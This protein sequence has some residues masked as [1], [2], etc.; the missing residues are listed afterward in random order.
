ML[1]TCKVPSHCKS[2]QPCQ[3]WPCKA[4]L[5]VRSGAR[6][7][8]AIAVIAINILLLIATSNQ[9]TVVNVEGKATLPKLV[10]ASQPY[11]RN[12]K[13]RILHITMQHQSTHQVSTDPDE[14][15]QE[16]QEDQSAPYG[17][18]VNSAKGFPDYGD[19]FSDKRDDLPE[20]LGWTGSTIATH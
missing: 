10:T 15:V 4:A 18:F 16:D 19:Y 2:Q 7:E 3:S 11:N 12:R 1:R 9:L 6:E 5:E 14:S 17:L 20:D 13:G 8:S